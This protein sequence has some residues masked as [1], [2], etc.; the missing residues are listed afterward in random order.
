MLLENGFCSFFTPQAVE[1][2]KKKIRSEEK[3]RRGMTTQVPMHSS[4]ENKPIKHDLTPLFTMRG[5]HEQFKKR[6]ISKDTCLYLEY[7]IR[8]SWAW[9]SSNPGIYRGRVRF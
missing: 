9:E 5:E 7:K 3:K 4:G 6:G 1:V 2:A 8:L